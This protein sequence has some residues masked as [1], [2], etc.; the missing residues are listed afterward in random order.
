M[1]NE[2]AIGYAILAAKQIGLTREQIK[3]LDRAMYE[4]MDEV[5]ESEAEEVYRK[6]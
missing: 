4:V 6:T 1:N 3:K 5:T 2:A